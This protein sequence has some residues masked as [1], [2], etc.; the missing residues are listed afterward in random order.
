MGLNFERIADTANGALNKHL[1]DNFIV[2]RR[3]DGSELSEKQIMQLTRPYFKMAE[4]TEDSDQ[5]KD[6]EF[7][8]EETP[9]QKQFDAVIKSASKMNEETEAAKHFV[10][11]LI[12]MCEP[13]SEDGQNQMALYN[14]DQMVCAFIAGL[15]WIR[16]RA[17]S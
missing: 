3:I 17:T 8:W 9:I 12:P 6:V 7:R 14:Y 16:N 4:Y 5:Q 11:T 10:D 13:V 15:Q 1:I 2:T